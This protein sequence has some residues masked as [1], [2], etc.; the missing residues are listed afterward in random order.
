VKAIIFYL[1]A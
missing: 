1:L